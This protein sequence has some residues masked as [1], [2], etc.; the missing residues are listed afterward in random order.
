MNRYCRLISCLLIPCAFCL[1]PPVFTARAQEDGGAEIARKVRGEMGLVPV[2]VPDLE[3]LEKAVRDQVGEA[4]EMLRKSFDAMLAGRGQ[5][6]RAYL[7]L[8]RLYHAYE[9]NGAAESCYRNAGILDPELFGWR[10]NLGYLLQSIG[11]YDEALR[12]FQEELVGS[13]YSYLLLIRMGECHRSLGRLAEAR[14][15]FE[16]AFALNPEGPAVLAR[17]GE[18]A[19]EQK[20][21]REAIEFLETALSKG[22]SVNK[23]HYPL[24]MAYRGLGEYEKARAHLALKGIV[25]IQPPDPLKRQLD[26]LVTGYQIHLLVGQRAY[27]AERY[28]EAAA[29]FQ[30][31]VDADPGRHGARINLA[32]ALVKER[33]YREAVAQLQEAVRLAPESETAHYNLGTLLAH[34][35]E[36]ER[37][38]DHLRLVV[39]KTPEDAEVQLVLADTLRDSG[40]FAEAFERYKVSV[41]LEPSQTS[42]WLEMSKLCS[43]AGQHGDA[44]KVLEEAHSRSPNNGVVKHALARHLAASPEPSLRD[45]ARATDLAKS[46]FQ[47]RSEYRHAWTVAMALAESGRC[48]EAAEWQERSI[49]IAG[50]SGVA[51]PP[52]DLLKADLAYF[53]ENRPCRVPLGAVSP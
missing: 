32:S 12:L 49:S 53:L 35:G 3:P 41:R 38:L 48:D 5:Y 50:E 34:L 15:A 51:G 22:P 6:G 46:A 26:E 27:G 28:A 30:K 23:L 36:H 7:E 25:G 44:V 10:Y 13:E 16:E 2:P 47:S 21:Y 11:R 40:R 4:R 33:K 19:L 31:A 18:V 1:V 42:G 52:L 9:M 29:E 39:E 17:L 24:A 37:A 8:G 45:G 43:R 20:R 14:K